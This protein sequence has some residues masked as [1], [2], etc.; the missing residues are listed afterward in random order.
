MTWDGSSEPEVQAEPL[1]ATLQAIERSDGSLPAAGGVGELV[2]CAST[3][4]EQAFQP[5]L[6]TATDQRGG[7]APLLGLGLAGLGVGEVEL[8]DPRPQCGN[9]APELLGALGGGGLQRERAETAAHLILDVARAL[10]L[11]RDPGE[12]ELSPAPAPLELAEARGLFD[13]R[14][15]ILRLR[16]KH[17]LDLALAHDR[18]HRGAEPDVREELDEIGTAYRC[19]VDEVLPLAATDEPARDGDF[20]EVE[21]WPG[22]VLVRE[23]ELDLAVLRTLAITAAGEEHIV[24]L[25]RAQLGRRQ[26]ARRPDDRV[27]DVRLPRAVRPHDDGDAGLESDLERVRERLEA[28][29]AERA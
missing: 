20:R 22:T 17:L 12:L 7:V 23:D 29:D 13:E 24:G 27:G 10:H 16:R 11:E 9:L 6:R 5:R 8:C 28:A 21:R 25:L 3:I 1:D 14:P 18:V 2:L 4:R 15:P 19:A 26:G